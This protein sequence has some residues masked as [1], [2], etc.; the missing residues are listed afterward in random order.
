MLAHM[1]GDG[2]RIKRQPVRYASIDEANLSAVTIA[3]AHFGVTPIRDGYAAARVTTMRLPAPYR[4]TH[5]RRN[6]IAEWLDGLGLYGF[7]QLRKVRTSRGI[8]STERAGGLVPAAS[9]GDRWI[10][11]LGCKDRS[12]ADLLPRQA[13]D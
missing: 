11:S 8:R 10:C 2:S 9:L 6:P 12:G 3:A 4:L 5:G 1:I 13:A 7:A